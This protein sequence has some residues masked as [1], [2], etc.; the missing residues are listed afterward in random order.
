VE[1]SQDLILLFKIH[2][3][4]RKNFFVIYNLSTR[5]Q[6]GS[7]ALQGDNL[8]FAEKHGVQLWTGCDSCTVGSMNTIRTAHKQEN[9]YPA[10]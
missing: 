8:T 5:P 2:V 9:S 4:T 10:A 6:K 7:K 3:G 1:D